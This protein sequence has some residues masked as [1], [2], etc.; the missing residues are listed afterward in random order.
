MLYFYKAKNV[1]WQSGNPTVNVPLDFLPALGK[2]RNALM[3]ERIHILV[4]LNITTAGGVSIVQGEDFYTFLKAIRVYDSEGDRRLMTGLE[5]FVKM[6]EDNGDAVPTPPTTH[7]ASTTQDDYCEFIIN[8]SQPTRAHRRNDYLM[9]VEDMLNGGGIE[10]TLPVAADL[11]ATG[12]VPT[13]N[14]GTIYITVV[15]SESHDL[16]YP[17]RD[18]V[19]GYGFTSNTEFYVPV[20]NKLVRSL[21][22]YLLTAPGFANWNSNAAGYLATCEPYGLASIQTVQMRRAYLTEFGHSTFDPVF[23]GASAPLVFPNKADKI[24][25][26]KRIGGN[27]LVRL[28]AGAAAAFSFL[29]HTIA[30]KSRA[31]VEAAA[32]RRGKTVDAELKLDG[33]SGDKRNPGRWGDMS[34]FMAAKQ[35][36]AA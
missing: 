25:D 10:L 35:K 15:C 24:P 32:A 17:V 34:R 22:M 21:Q 23:T 12:G 20:S 19:R 28:D 27:L 14:S 8:F 7:A 18:I 3:L 9:P 13:I 36:K 2:R 26:M 30:P 31:I 16:Q 4:V 29:L 33:T 11:A 1:A 6:M 5:S